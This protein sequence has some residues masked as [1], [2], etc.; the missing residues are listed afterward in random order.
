L[1]AVENEKGSAWNVNARLNYTGPTRFPMLWGGYDRGFLMPLRN[2]SL[3]IRTSAGRA[4]GPSGDTFASFYFGGFGNNWIDKDRQLAASAPTDF[5][6]YRGYF[7][8]PGTQLNAIGGRDYVKSTVEWDLPPLRFRSAGW[9]SVYFN[10]VR[11]ALFG[12]AL[13]TDLG[14]GALRTSYTD[15]GAQVD[16]RLVWFTYMKSTFSVGFGVARDQNGHTGTEKMI[17]LKLN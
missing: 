14:N 12:G 9:T 5:S 7:S 8:F 11:L 13:G 15:A 16:L 2:S 17:S 1:G 3:W 4:F 6:R 10:W